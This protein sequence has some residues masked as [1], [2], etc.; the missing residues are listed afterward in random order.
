MP[1]WRLGTS[2]DVNGLVRK[3]V[4]VHSGNNRVSIQEI[5]SGVYVARISQGKIVIFRGKLIILN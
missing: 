3:S 5:P 2:E 1:V 4:E